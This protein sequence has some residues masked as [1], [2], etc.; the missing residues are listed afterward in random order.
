[1][2]YLVRQALLVLQVKMVHLDHPD[3]REVQVE[4]DLLVQLDLLEQQVPLEQPVRLALKDL[5][6]RP[7]LFMANLNL[8]ISRPLPHPCNQ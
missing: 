1:L 6:E 2:V 8:T 5:L 3:L 4:V 7:R